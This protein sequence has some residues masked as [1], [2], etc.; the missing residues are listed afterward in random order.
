[1]DNSTCKIKTVKEL[2]FSKHSFITHS[3]R[4]KSSK[5]RSGGG[6]IINQAF[7]FYTWKLVM[8]SET[9]QSNE[10]IQGQPEDTSLCGE[11]SLVP[12]CSDPNQ[13]QN[14]LKG[15]DNTLTVH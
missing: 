4:E 2:G 10:N 12:H 14:N 11:S 7:I 1:M 9:H 8:V 15:L 6:F 5:L 3:S 13:I